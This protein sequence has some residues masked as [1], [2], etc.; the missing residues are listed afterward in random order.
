[1]TYR[2]SLPLFSAFLI[3]SRL[4]CWDER[5]FYIEQTFTAREGL[6]ALG[7]VKG[8]L[9]DGRN[10][11]EPQRVLERVAPSGTYL[12]AARA[13]AADVAKNPPLGVRSTIRARRWYM[14]QLS[15]EVLMQVNL[16]K[17]HLTEDFAESARAFT[18]KRPAA[19]F[20]GR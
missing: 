15:R 14:G 13:L 19:P 7:W 10:I 4:V 3:T 6:S 18:E 5:W 20:K 9:R 12:D 2:R 17:L 16:A 11:L 8:M 1:M